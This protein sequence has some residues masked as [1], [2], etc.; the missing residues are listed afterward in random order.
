MDI[1][2]QVAIKRVGGVARPHRR[3]PSCA[4]TLSTAKLG[5][6]GPNQ[7]PSESG[8][9]TRESQLGSQ[10]M[11]GRRASLVLESGAVTLPNG[12][13]GILFLAPPYQ[14]KSTLT[15]GVIVRGGRPLSD[16]LVVVNT[17]DGKLQPYLTPSGIR[18]E[19][20]R[21]LMGVEG[22][23]HNIRPEWITVSEVTGPVYLLHFDLL[24]ASFQL[25]EATAPVLLV[26]PKN[27]RGSGMA[28]PVM[29][30]LS[31]SEAWEWAD[32]RRVRN[33]E[34][35]DLQQMTLRR[36]VNEC[37]SVEL[38]FDLVAC[39]FDRVIESILAL[40]DGSRRLVR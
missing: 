26:F 33:T 25:P 18:H 38:V 19:T 3:R 37:P 31:R 23:V 6:V 40:A 14:G 11:E 36:M 9:V 21:H 39:D 32:A 1:G 34:S 2:R 7:R 10:L 20:I 17:D 16:N 35:D 29:R 15:N 12:N 8:V 24:H 30:A 27:V 22:A 4:K 28:G 13:G 5:S